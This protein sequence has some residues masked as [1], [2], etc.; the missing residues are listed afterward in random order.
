MRKN[1]MLKKTKKSR[2]YSVLN[3]NT[4]MYLKDCA[5]HGRRVTTVAEAFQDA[6]SNWKDEDFAG[7]N[8]MDTFEREMVL[9]QLGY[10][11]IEHNYPIKTG[12]IK[13]KK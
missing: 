5:N 7:I 9:K 11:V 6:T 12:L 13:W 2:F 10:L 3:C 4:G 8:R 1:F